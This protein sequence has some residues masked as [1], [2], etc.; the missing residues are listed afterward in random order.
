MSNVA[1]RDWSQYVMPSFQSRP[2]AIV[3]KFV[4]KDPQILSRP[5]RDPKLFF[6]HDQLDKIAVLPANWDTNQSAKPDSVAIE[7]AR[8]MLED[9]FRHPS[10]ASIWQNPYLSVSEDGEVVLEWWN[11]V[12]KLTI[13]VGAEG[14]TFLKSWGL[15]LINDME[16]G[17]LPDNWVPRIWAWLF[18]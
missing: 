4:E 6:L 11:G 5:A 14:A 7:N 15:H 18:E 8:Q 2:T 12:R 17:V 1:A 13:Y 3:Y 9:A 10:T 16:D